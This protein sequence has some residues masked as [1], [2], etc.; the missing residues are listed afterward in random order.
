V[1]LDTPAEPQ[2]YQPMLFGGSQIVVRT[3][4]EPARFVETLRSELLAADPRVMIE[5]I[6]PLDAIAADSIRERRLTAQLVAAFAALALL[7]ALIGIYGITHFSTT[8]RRRE[9]GVRS[10]LGARRADIV[11]LVLRE[12]LVL[13]A[14]GTVIGIVLSVPLAASLQQLLFETRAVDPR[15][16]AAAIALLA[17]GC[18]AACAR[19][20][21]RAASVDPAIAL[22][23]H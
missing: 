17:A 20:A 21:W 12:G 23:A 2:W 11:R 18:A 19:P 14:A 8:Q 10:A 5:R 1:R 7:L 3:R 9:F 4:H 13:T 16:M 15:V 6:E 22:R